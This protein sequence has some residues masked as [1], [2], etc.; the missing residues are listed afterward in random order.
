MSLVVCTALLVC[1][2]VASGEIDVARQLLRATGITVEYRALAI[3]LG[4]EVSVVTATPSMTRDGFEGCRGPLSCAQGLAGN[5]ARTESVRSSVL[6]DAS[7]MAR[8]K[9]PRLPGHALSYGAGAAEVAPVAT[10]AEE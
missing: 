2:P 8:G 4:P 7:G 10:P 6:S 3:A 5:E 9:G 1:Q